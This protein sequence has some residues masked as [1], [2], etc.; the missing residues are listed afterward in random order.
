MRSSTEEM[1]SE[2]PFIMFL[3]VINRS[4]AFWL[5][6]EFPGTEICPGRA[7]TGGSVQVRG[8]ELGHQLNCCRKDY[9]SAAAR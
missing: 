8:R 5:C 3:Q 1:F 2:Q 6:L 7:E 4:T 9:F